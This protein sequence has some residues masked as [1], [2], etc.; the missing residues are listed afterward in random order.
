MIIGL[1]ENLL[2]WGVG[3]RRVGEFSGG[4]GTLDDS[5]SSSRPAKVARAGVPNREVSA[6]A[7]GREERACLRDGRKAGAGRLPPPQ[8]G[9]RFAFLC[10]VSTETKTY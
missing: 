8:C 2:G 4:G 3:V 10:L 7:R 6:K 9:R 5:S 1:L